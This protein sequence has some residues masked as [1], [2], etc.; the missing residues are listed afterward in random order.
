M[1]ERLRRLRKERGLTQVAME[2]RTGIEQTLLS[3]YERGERVPPTETLMLLARFFHTSMDY[4]AGLTD[5]PQPYP[6]A[7][8]MGDSF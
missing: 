8:G 4:I 7:R 3:K 5:C 6:A 1:G 2:M